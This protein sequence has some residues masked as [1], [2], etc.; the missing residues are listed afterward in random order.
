MNLVI[1]ASV[2]IAWI[3][4]DERSAYAEA[5]LAACGSDPASVPQLWHWEIANALLVLERKGRL[6]DAAAVYASVAQSLPIHAERNPSAS[7]TNDEIEVARRHGLSVYDAAYLAL[8]KSMGH[9]LATL[10]AKL[11]EAAK[12]EAVFFN[13]SPA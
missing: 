12:Q 4:A 6:T 10:D 13:P 9:Q 5:A 1:D 2:T 7:R 11:A 3:A 8:A